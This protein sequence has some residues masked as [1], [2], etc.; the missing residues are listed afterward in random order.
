MLSLTTV[1]Q[2]IS[3]NNF[4]PQVKPKNFE[5]HFR[6]QDVL[7]NPNPAFVVYQCADIESVIEMCKGGEDV[8]VF[9]VESGGHLSSVPKSLWFKKLN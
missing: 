6:V 9:V 2:I 4:Q 5:V 7:W 1:E 8:R 3:K